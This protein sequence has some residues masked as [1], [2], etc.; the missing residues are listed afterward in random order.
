MHVALK[1][2]GELHVDLTG[3][4]RSWQLSSGSLQKWRSIQLG[5][6]HPD[7]PETFPNI[8]DFDTSQWLMIHP[9]SLGRK[10][11]WESLSPPALAKS[12]VDNQF[13]EIL[14]LSTLATY[15]YCFH[16]RCNS[17]TSNC[18]QHMGP[19]TGNHQNSFVKYISPMDPT[20]WAPINGLITPSKWSFKSVTGVTH[21]RKWSYYPTLKL[22]GASWLVAAMVSWSRSPTTSL[23]ATW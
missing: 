23:N 12:R 14:Q 19:R 15:G 8:W 7:F 17:L 11:F 13:F 2:L 18:F 6:F 5:I 10:R 20:S 16:R 1:H 4:P 21:T 3:A 22:G 9:P